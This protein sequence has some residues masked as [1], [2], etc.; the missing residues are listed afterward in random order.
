MIDSP[1]IMEEVAEP[2]RIARARAHDQ[3]LKRNLDWLNAHWDDLLPQ[4]RGRYVAVAGQEPFVADTYADAWAM[5]TAAHPDDDGA[6]G[7]Y[8]PQV[9]EN[10]VV[11]EVETDPERLA[12]GQAQH[13]RFKRNVDWLQAHWADLLPR[14]LG[15]HLVVAGQEAFIADTHAEAL[16]VAKAVHPDDDGSFGQYVLPHRG[17]RIYAHRPS[18]ATDRTLENPL[19]H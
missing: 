4:A 9:N 11:V 6:W 2:D 3:R 12:R 7:Q 5:A 15:K 10:F 1:I 17:P 13:E 18:F 8:V 19:A 16:A 14:A